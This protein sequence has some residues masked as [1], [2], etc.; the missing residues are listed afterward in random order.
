MDTFQTI[1]LS[2]AAI[3]LIGILIVV[4]MLMKKENITAPFPP[5]ST[6]CPDGWSSYGKL[7]I[8]DASNSGVFYKSNITNSLFIT[9]LSNN[10]KLFKHFTPGLAFC[11]IDGSGNSWKFN[12]NYTDTS[13]NDVS[14]NKILYQECKN[15][16]TIPYNIRQTNDASNGILMTDELWAA[17]GKSARCAKKAWANKFGFTWDGVSNYNSC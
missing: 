6:D 13:C 17:G 12:T 14:N 7:C 16:L 11:S 1:V 4:G 2:I 3:V 8:P 15:C 10:E 5:V 9:D